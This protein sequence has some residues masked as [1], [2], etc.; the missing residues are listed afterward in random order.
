MPINETEYVVD[1]SDMVNGNTLIERIPTSTLSENEANG[2]V[3]MREEEKLARDIY[4]TLGA[5]WGMRV[6]TN[7]AASEQ[8]HTD[9]VKVM[10]DRYFIADPSIDNTVGVF[11]APAIQKLYNDLSAK[12]SQSLADALYVGAMVEDMDIQSLEVLMKETVKE[13]ILALYSNLQKGSRNHMRAFV[14]SLAATGTTYSPQYISQDEFT[15]IMSRPQERG[16]I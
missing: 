2:L 8:T 6:F 13:D 10:L 11:R 7:I 3:R 16:R 12:G 5:K 15:V 1:E 4:T 14:K 9:A